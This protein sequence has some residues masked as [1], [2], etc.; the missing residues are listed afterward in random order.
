MKFSVC[1]Y[2]SPLK[3]PA[4]IANTRPIKQRSIEHF[5]IECRKTKTKVITQTNHK[6]CRA[7]HCPIKTRS[8]YTK[9]G[10][11]CA[12]KS[13]LALGLLVIGLGFTSDWSRK[14]NEFLSTS[15]S[16]AWIAMQNQSKRELLLILK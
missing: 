10:K 13:R 8:N 3:I 5:L 16:I 7:I 15:L 11:T 12:S 14:W 9:R 6:R 1:S 2:T 4:V